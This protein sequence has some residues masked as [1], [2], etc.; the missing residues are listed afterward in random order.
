MKMTQQEIN[1]AEPSDSF[2]S[3]IIKSRKLTQSPRI[4][5]LMAMLDHA[6]ICMFIAGLINGAYRMFGWSI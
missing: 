3:N 4:A 2:N 5:L 1:P 6:I